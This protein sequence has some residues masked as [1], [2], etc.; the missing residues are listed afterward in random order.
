MASLLDLSAKN[1]L[2]RIK[3]GIV[4]FDLPAPQLGQL[5][6]ALFKA[7]GR[8][9]ISSP[10][11]LP[12]Q[13]FDN[14]VDETTFATWADQS[15]TL[16]HPSYR[17]VNRFSS[18]V[19]ALVK[20][21]IDAGDKRSDVELTV[22]ARHQIEEE[23]DQDLK[24]AMT[25]L[26]R[27]AREALLDTG[28][29]CLH[30]ALGAVVWKEESDGRGAGKERQWEAPLYLYP[31]ILEGGRRSPYTVRLD[32]SGE[33]TPNHCLREKLRRE[34]YNLE[35]PELVN[36][37]TDEFG[38]DFDA[39]FNS[40]RARFEEAKLH[41]FAVV[42]K[43][44]LGVFDYSTFRLWSDLHSGWEKMVEQS[45]AA[46]HLILTPNQEFVEPPQS[47]SEQLEPYSPIDADD[48]QEK[49]IAWALQG[50]SFRL[51]GPPGTGKTQT[52][53]NLL[54]SCLAHGKKI[55]FVAEKQPALDQVKKRMSSIGLANYCLDL[56]A[57]GDSDTR[58]R[59][60]IQT[61]LTSAL[62]A[63]ADAREQ[64]WEQVS[65]SLKRKIVLF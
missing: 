2:L 35:L 12:S 57:Q 16:I 45:D 13:W 21:T 59:K 46:R 34:P 27:K 63:Q 38:L 39:M 49:A 5:D 52:I 25:A 28:T 30:L 37:D 47:G 36:P 54:A 6:D 62:A 55:L 58:I 23:Y 7:N 17:E 48:S 33:A 40:L 51:E 22:L 19:K 3:K 8:I 20:N 9:T 61:A 41:N 14:G 50:R 32:P 29:N 1:P 44:Y 64:D 42:P 26:T 60:N 53:T 43:A 15:D 10:S 4:S 11:R 31:V 24:K 65:Y 18:R 56:H